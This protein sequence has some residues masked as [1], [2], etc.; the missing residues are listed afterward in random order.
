MIVGEMEVQGQVRRAHELARDAGT[1]GPMLHRL[2]QAALAT[3]KRIRTETT[4]SEGRAS[5]SSVAVRLAQDTLGHLRDRHVVVVGAGETSELTAQALAGEGVATVFLAN[6]RADR[7]R[8]IAQRFGGHVVPL[9]DLPQQ[10]VAADIVVSSTSS[11]HPIIGVAEL[12]QVVDERDGRPLLMI[13]I[14]VPRDIDPACG[15]LDGVSL[16]DIDDLQTVVAATLSSRGA[17]VVTATEIVEDEIK[18][19]AHWMG[20]QDVLPAIAD[21][22]EHGR[23]IVDQVL[24]ENRGRWEGATER[25][26]ARIDAVAR[27]VMQRLLH[28][29]TIR[30]RESGHGRV[31]LVREL[32][33]LDAG[34]TD[35]TEAEPDAQT[36]DNVRQLRG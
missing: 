5:V 30:L 24:A 20:Q 17:E 10:L 6:R 14:A 33:G 28:E 13:D 34:P 36:R 19:F 32:F 23:D 12:E 21:L 26:L 11:P 31:E 35:G 7:A 8:S 22:R 4:L 25:D 18:R 29:P 2:F 27:A 1:V 3:G 15:D 9:H 16:Y